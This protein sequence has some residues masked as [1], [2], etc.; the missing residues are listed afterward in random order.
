MNDLT[1][2]AQEPEQR[3]LAIQKIY[4]KDAS[5]EVPNAPHVFTQNWTPQAKVDLDSAID[6][7]SEELF[8]LVLTVTVTVSMDEATAF[9]VEVHQAGL[10]TLSGWSEAERHRLLGTFCAAQLFPF[11]REAIADLSG[12]AGFPPLLLAPV[13]FDA[14]YDT[15][16]AQAEAGGLLAGA[17][18]VVTGG[19]NGS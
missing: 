19:H 12:K 4:L 15:R 10:F 8:H 13:N 16:L 18:S 14:L 9:L 1:A 5:L 2:T 6:M 11:A 17:S 7:L 3:Q